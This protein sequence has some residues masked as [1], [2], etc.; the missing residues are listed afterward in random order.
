M[1]DAV[2]VLI[3]PRSTITADRLSLGTAAAVVGVSGLISAL[4][5]LADT[6]ASGE[7]VSA[8]ADGLALVATPSLFFLIWAGGGRLVDLGARLMGRERSLQ[9]LLTAS[10]YAVVPLAL[11]GLIPLA[12]TLAQRAG[13]GDGLVAIIGVLSLAGVAWY[14]A[15]LSI[16]AIHVYD[17]NAASALA[18][19]LM[20]VAVVA[21]LVLLVIVVFAVTHP[22]S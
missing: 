10:A 1:L 5:G 22:G 18:L 15:L 16:A 17:V 19:A 13:A 7:Q 2:R 21:A 11:T 4:L 6:A 9:R 3:R 8:Q 12:Q 20:P 14:V